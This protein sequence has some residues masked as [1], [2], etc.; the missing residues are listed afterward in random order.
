M[1]P[2]PHQ[3]QASSVAALLQPPDAG[4]SDASSCYARPPCALGPTCCLALSSLHLHHDLRNC[5]W[6][7]RRP[8]RVLCRL[9]LLILPSYVA[10]VPRL[11]RPWAPLLQVWCAAGRMGACLGCGAGCYG[12]HLHLHL[13]LQQL[14]M[15]KPCE[16]LLVG[17]PFRDVCC[18]LQQP[19]QRRRSAIRAVLHRCI[20]GPLVL[21][22]LHELNSN[23]QRRFRARDANRC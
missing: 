18:T 15:Y 16:V 9:Q 4:P 11:Y 2:G 7:H 1:Q 20:G 19:R 14:A 21:L 23:M 13:G 3:W 12:C 6:A 8:R 5:Q 10:A 17:Q 22:G